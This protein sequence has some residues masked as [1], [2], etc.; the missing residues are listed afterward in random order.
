MIWDAVPFWSAA[1]IALLILCTVCREWR[2]VRT[3]GVLF[4]NHML[5]NFVVWLTGRPDPWAFFWAA[6]FFSGVIVLLA[7]NSKWQRYV[8]L[9]YFVMIGVHA[10]YGLAL[11][12]DAVDRYLTVLDLGLAAQIAVVATWVGW[13]A[14]QRLDP[15]LPH[16]IGLHPSAAH[17]EGF[18]G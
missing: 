15:G 4:A 17:R 12:R 8:G 14:I 6:D 10:S 18:G 5:C 2:M 3:S 7:P 16:R 13:H 1:L 9:I 11:H